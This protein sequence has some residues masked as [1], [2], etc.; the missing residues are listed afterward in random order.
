[1]NLH[2]TWAATVIEALNTPF[3]WSSGHLALGVDDCNVTPEPMHPCFHGSLDWHSSCHMQWSAV[4]LLPQ[5]DAELRTQ[6]IEVLDQ[7]LTRENADVE[8]AYLRRHPSFERPYGWGWLAMLA[9]AASASS[10][11]R[12][13]VW[14]QALAP[15]VDAVADSVLAWLPRQALPVR[16][17]THQNTAFG[18]SLLRDGFAHL[19]RRDVVAA[20][21][22]RARDWFAADRDYPSQWEPSGTDFLSPALSEA[23]LMR[24][25]LGDDFPSWLA[26]FL[27]AL[28]AP[29]DRLL[30]VPP[31]LDRT[32]GHLVHLFGLGLSRAAQLRA[33]A[34]Y[35]TPA[36]ADRA[37]V[38]ASEQAAAA[39]P[40]ISGGDF[41][42]THWLVSFA[43]LAT[44]SD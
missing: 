13:S 43:L 30:A 42:S 16:H 7:R 22:V 35:L 6:L 12:A 32:D 20:V 31:V 2:P 11:P 39:L 24:R 8:A 40:E 5:V 23:D 28:G 14:S 3:P 26:K 9:A 37:R 17:G 25:V 21:D 33:L 44:A 10:E 41:M 29:G 34:P 4:Q 18:L 19:R 38:A 27:P 36:D 15:L 1:M